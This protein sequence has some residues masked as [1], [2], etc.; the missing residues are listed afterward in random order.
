[1]EKRELQPGDLLQFNPEHEVYGGQIVMVTEPKCFGCQGVLFLDREYQNLSRYKGR[2]FI[3][4]KFEEVEFIGRIEWY[5]EDAEE[6][7]N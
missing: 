6:D 5:Y 1:M 7:Q 4:P 3:R 2:A